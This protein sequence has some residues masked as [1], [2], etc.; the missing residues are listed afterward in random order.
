MWKENRGAGISIVVLD[1][2]VNVEHPDLAAHT[3]EGISVVEDR[4][5]FRVTEGFADTLG[6]GTA[7]TGILKR[8]VPEAD[9]F[10]V[11]VFHEE[12]STSLE[13]LLYAMEY[14]L[15]NIDCHILHLSLGVV[16]DS[17]IKRL[18][19][20]CES[21]TAKGVLI[22]SA[23]DN[24]GAVSYP[25]A[26]SEV[27]GVDAS[28]T[29]KG[30]HEFEFVEGSLVNLKA[31]G[32]SQRLAWV[33]PTYIFRAGASFAAAYATA[34]V[35]KLRQGGL[36][37]REE[38]LAELQQEAVK[39]FPARTVR[40][41][42]GKFP[43]REAV[44]FPFNK[45][46]HS[47]ARFQDLLGFTLRGVYDTKYSGQVGQP[48]SKV[49]RQPVPDDH[50]IQNLDQ[51]NWHDSWDAL[52]LGHV[53]LLSDKVGVDYI[54]TLL[55]LCIEHRK[56]LYCYDGLG[57]YEELVQE[58]RARGL[59]VF[60][61]E[62][63]AE[64]VPPN[65]FGKLRKIGKPVLGIFGTSSQQGKFTLQLNLR[66]RFL[67]DGYAVGQLG[68]E[69]S[70]LLYGFDEVYPMGYN[71]TVDVM[72]YQ[73]VTV[74]N[75]MMWRI[76][77]GDPDIILVGSQSGT[78]PYDTG[79]LRRFTYPAINFLLGTQPDAY[80]LCVNVE[81]DLGYIRRSVQVLENLG[82]GKVIGL[83][84]FPLR[85]QF[86]P[87][88]GVKMNPGQSSDLLAFKETLHAELGLS[89]FVM[90]DEEELESLYQRV[91]EFYS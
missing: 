35:A 20:L 57:R 61:P 30:D 47:V 22:V 15:H 34:A 87:W 72:A 23:F 4:D 53:E 68:T 91:L 37:E 86:I 56:N 32:T 73:A 55:Q 24:D 41:T 18:R 82:T 88:A 11:K 80:I 25:A 54:E 13:R 85:K 64:E 75:E 16:Q 49:L 69:P 6:H 29:C 77:D 21:L 58:A 36:T 8:L 2:G 60:Y 90:N 7:V 26:F 1:S 51:L 89:A 12:L 65:R 70:A 48:I 66:R 78:V 9:I 76:E 39:V 17:E 52:I 31:K 59:S 63:S 3:F 5:G 46:M 74:L 45:E 19:S 38:I 28:Q 27:I 79:N 83:G 84:V 33:Q 81:D 43:V 71:S 14:V 10:A 62:V 42:S 40:E 67:R 50:V 44:I